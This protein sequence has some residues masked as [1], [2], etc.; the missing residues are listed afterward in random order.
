M[1]TKKLNLANAKC[2]DMSR[3][4]LFNTIAFK[5]SSYGDL[6]NVIDGINNQLSSVDE[7]RLTQ[8][9]KEALEKR[10][11]DRANMLA[12][13][14]PASAAAKTPLWENKGLDTFT[15]FTSGYTGSSFASIDRQANTMSSPNL[16]LDDLTETTSSNT[17]IQLS[18][19]MSTSQKCN[20]GFNVDS[21]AMKNE[22]YIMGKD[23]KNISRA[24]SENFVSK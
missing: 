17:K 20:E 3:S 23:K 6:N 4:D 8:E 11:L 16:F 15:S 19:E 14:R 2:L 22:K 9:G 18:M 10:R 1:D 7:T 24:S 21:K 5:Y 13:L 12:K